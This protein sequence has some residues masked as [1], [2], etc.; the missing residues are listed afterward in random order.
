M[1]MH[2]TLTERV[3][4]LASL[5]IEGM[6][7]VCLP[8]QPTLTKCVLVPRVQRPALRQP[9]EDPTVARPLG[10]PRVRRM[11]GAFFA[12]VARGHRLM[13]SSIGHSEPARVAMRRFATFGWRRYA[14][15]VS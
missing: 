7:W 14:W 10:I 4:V 15:A 11:R 6:L 1:G 2:M 5:A 9:T 12:A 8:F 3:G 13:P